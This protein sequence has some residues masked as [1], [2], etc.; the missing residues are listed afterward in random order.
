MFQREPGYQSGSGYRAAL[1]VRAALGRCRLAREGQLQWLRRA[2]RTSSRSRGRDRDSR[3]C[4]MPWRNAAS[5]AYC[6]YGRARAR[7][8]DADALMH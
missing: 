6:S 1:Q 5:S 4:S 2:W 8:G 3:D 7:Y